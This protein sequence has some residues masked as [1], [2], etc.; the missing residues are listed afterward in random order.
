MVKNL[1]IGG[2]T[3]VK[4]VVENILGKH[5]AKKYNSWSSRGNFLRNSANRLRRFGT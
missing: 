2:F 1:D 4:C 5:D 3:I